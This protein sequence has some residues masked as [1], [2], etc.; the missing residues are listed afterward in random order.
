MAS[1]SSFSVYTK[2]FLIK[3]KTREKVL[4]LICH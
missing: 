3:K 1:S 2:H 4:I